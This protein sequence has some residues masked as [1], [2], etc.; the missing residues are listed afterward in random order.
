M[1]L[2]GK[3]SAKEESALVVVISGAKQMAEKRIH[4]IL[5]P[6]SPFPELGLS[7]GW[8]SPASVIQVMPF[9]PAKQDSVDL[10]SEALIG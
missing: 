9:S 7:R 3:R 2:R 10:R 6:C 4:L 5:G 8:L 1:P